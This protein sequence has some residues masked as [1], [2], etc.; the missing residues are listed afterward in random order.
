MLEL[1]KNNLYIENKY[2]TKCFQLIIF[3]NQLIEK[4]SDVLEK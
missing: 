3:F 1:F 2:L 4:T